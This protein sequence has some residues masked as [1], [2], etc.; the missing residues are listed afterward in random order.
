MLPAQSPRL[1]SL[2]GGTAVALGLALFWFLRESESIPEPEAP[3]AGA[4]QVSAAPQ[5]DAALVE[6]AALRRKV[7]K[8]KV[9]PKAK[10]RVSKESLRA[11]A[12][13][14]TVKRKAGRSARSRS[15]SERPKVEGPDLVPFVVE[16]RLDTSG[17]PDFD[18]LAS[19]KYHARLPGGEPQRNGRAMFRRFRSFVA[20]NYLDPLTAPEALIIH[21]DHPGALPAE[22]V[23]GRSSWV[24][25]GEGYIARPTLRFE[26]IDTTISIGV[27]PSP[28]VRPFR[29]AIHLLEI[30]ALGELSVL[31]E[32]PLDG[33]FRRKK[34]A[35]LRVRRGGG[36][37]MAIALPST[38]AL[39]PD[40]LM[41]KI[42]G[43]PG[44]HEL[45]TG[46]RS[47]AYERR[48]A[49]VLDPFGEPFKGATLTGV[50]DE[51]RIAIRDA[52]A[53]APVMYRGH[54]FIHTPS[55]RTQGFDGT[56]TSTVSRGAGLGLMA[57]RR[58]VGKETKRDGVIDLTPI[59]E[60]VY[61]FTI[62]TPLNT[63]A[64]HVVPF[65]LS[66]GSTLHKGRWA[67]TYAI[68]APVGGIQVERP[69]SLGLRSN[70]WKRAKITLT[71][72]DE[73]ITIAVDDG[74]IARGCVPPLVP[75]SVRV[76]SG[77]SVFT[78]KVAPMGYGDRA[79]AIPVEVPDDSK[80]D[81]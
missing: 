42:P 4:V 67:P 77:K 21:F 25:S 28:S 1:L 5:E 53:G 44:D 14:A 64:I 13:K 75:V 49:K 11:R 51:N 17:I 43:A 48:I 58:A 3:I 37:L 12:A 56:I 31:D 71:A 29:G 47:L 27:E 40:L 32:Q 54:V 34:K 52:A 35:R 76:E 22:V 45:L 55:Q 63:E 7:P 50:V 70:A 33:R 36:T 10:T 23:L 78:A 62:R 46:V 73:V 74:G 72:G 26:P 79:I 57:V 60:N 65:E 69:P 81:D 9:K 66:E 20:G 8:V 61:D 41:P 18:L 80:A 68:A 38:D 15:R 6:V 39:A 16:P 2:M 24:P 30:S 59:L 19:C